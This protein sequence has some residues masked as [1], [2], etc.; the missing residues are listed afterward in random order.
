MDRES[1]RPFS[2]TWSRVVN[3]SHVVHSGIPGW[4][5]DPEVKY[6]MVA[7]IS[8]QGYYLRQLCLGEHSATHM[9]APVSFHQ[10]GLSIDAYEAGSLV[11]PAV[12]VDMRERTT[13]DPDYCLTREDLQNW[14]LEFGVVPMR[15]VVLLCTG[16]QARWDR[17][18]EFFN[19]DDSG[20]F[21]FPGFGPEAARFLLDQRQVSGIGID[22]HGVDGGR[23]ETFAVNRLVLEQPR[24]VL[25]NLANL[26]QLP[27]TGATLV[28]GILRLKGG[29]GSP[30]SVLALVP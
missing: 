6:E 26:D 15:S 28:I 29:S 23:D 12:V 21:H 9:N 4:P 3:L 30:A 13:A 2:F 19:Q 18:G 27:P 25:E 10:C 17:P 11:A 5:G 8:E 1:G 7:Q 24:I 14:E 20:Q 16:W 22:T